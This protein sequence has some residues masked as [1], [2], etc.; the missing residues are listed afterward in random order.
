[1]NTMLTRTYVALLLLALVSGLGLGVMTSDSPDP[2]SRVNQDIIVDDGN[3]L[4]WI[5]LLPALTGTENSRAK[6]NII[7]DDGVPI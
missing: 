6:R 1:M 3:P 2:V 7:V 5:Q 4:G